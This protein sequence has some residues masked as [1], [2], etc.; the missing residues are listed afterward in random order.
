MFLNVHRTDHGYFVF[1]IVLFCR[2]SLF[3][4]G[5]VYPFLLK[6]AEVWGGRGWL[7]QVEMWTP[8]PLIN[9]R[10]QTLGQIVVCEWVWCSGV[11]VGPRF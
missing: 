7:G 4:S 6:V 11:L 5:L 2:S 1:D 8:N 10:T 9:L 3:P